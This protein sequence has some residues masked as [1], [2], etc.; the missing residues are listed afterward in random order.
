M[1]RMTFDEYDAILQEKS[2]KGIVAL[3]P[4]CSYETFVKIFESKLPEVYKTYWKECKKRDKSRKDLHNEKNPWF[5]LL[6]KNVTPEEYE[7]RWIMF[8]SYLQ[9]TG[10]CQNKT[11]EYMRGYIRQYLTT[12]DRFCLYENNMEVL[13]E[14][15]TNDKYSTFVKLFKKVEPALSLNDTWITF[16]SNLIQDENDK[17][18]SAT[19]KKICNY[20]KKY[21]ESK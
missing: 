21:L 1:I 20:V 17:E 11:Q 19:Q 15:Y 5:F 7:K 10:K 18:K 3:Y 16:L 13:Q 8:L 4:N 14:I 9:E 2:E 6:S 12:G